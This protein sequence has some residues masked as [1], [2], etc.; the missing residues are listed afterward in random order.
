M[1]LSASPDALAQN[2]VQGPF[3]SNNPGITFFTG[4]EG[5]YRIAASTASSISATIG[6]VDTVFLT[7][8]GSA[9]VSNPGG[10]PPNTQGGGVWVRG[11]GGTVETNTASTS[12]LN[13]TGNV[14]PGSPFLLQQSV[15]C[16]SVQRQDF[17]GVQVGT[18]V[19]RLNM[20]GWNVNIGTTAGYLSSRSEEQAGVFPF[21]TDVEVP[22]AG[23]YVVATWGSFFVDA[24]VRTQFYNMDL[25]SAANN[26]HNQALGAHGWSF[27]TSAGYQFQFGNNWFIEPSA[28]FVWSKTEVDSLNLV[29][30]PGNAISGT[31]TF[32]DIESQ[33]GRL[34]LRVGTT[35]AS[36]GL[37]LQPFVTGSV[38][39]EFADDATSI[40][41]T[42]VNCV[43]FNGL[44]AD[45]SIT[46]T[47]SRIGTYGQISAGIA[48][49]VTNTGWVGFVRGDYR[50]GDDLEGWTANAG[51][52]YNFLPALAAAPVIGKGPVY[53]APPPV[54]AGINWTGFYVGGFFGVNY[55]ESD[56]RFVNA[57]N[58]RSEPDIS[59]FIGGG[60][61]G[62]N[63]QFGSWVLGLEGDFGATNKNGARVC[64]TANG[65]GPTGAPTGAFSPFFFTC[66]NEHEWIATAAG[67]AGFTWDR[68]L[69][70]VKGG[71]A[72]TT[73]DFT[74]TCIAGPNNAIDRSCF[75]PAGVFVNSFGTSNDRFGWMAGLGTEFTLTPNW[76]AKA[77][78]NWIDFG[79]DTFVLTDGTTIT[80]RTTLTE[81]KVGVNYHFTPMTR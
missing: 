70:Y 75:S 14:A 18:D 71:G 57:V 68:A 74:A 42:C 61:V 24:M 78:F 44:P 80:D 31:L 50:K 35:F 72:W 66:Q 29:G 58:E 56:I 79:R 15:N 9:F 22:F 65:V 46:T 25:N 62:Y 6:N 49:Q 32:N 69:F 26:L 19:A 23:S 60:T 36:G 53:K 51:L 33:I 1:V 21:K 7:Q 5:T 48:G 54:V 45:A 13:M 81:V 12:N 8:Q 20:G 39:H 37:V 16:N 43:F 77:E 55:G 52:R 28:G 27:S 38:F 67:R 41:R 4:F 3:A 63:H 11:L 40:Y 17:A 76:S 2:C 30:Q 73:Q 34:T 59:G 47:A 10:A 64:G